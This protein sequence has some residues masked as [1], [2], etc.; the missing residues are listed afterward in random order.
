MSESKKFSLPVIGEVD[1]RTAM[2]AGAATL[3]LAA[4]AAAIK[5]WFEWTGELNTDDFLQKHYRELTHD[6]LQT[7]L[8]KL[9]D[10]ARKETG[11]NVTVKD[12]KPIL[13]VQFAYALNLSICIG[14]RRCAEACHVENNHD[15]PSHQSY[16]RVFEMQK[17]GIDFEKGNASWMNCSNRRTTAN[18][19]RGTGSTSSTSAKRM[20]TTRTNPDRT[21]G[22]TEIM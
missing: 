13:G 15:R 11:K 19:G 7:I 22:P 9:T 17:G 16:I 10:E 5:P 3:G 6:Q 18:A 21:P 14:C 12:H 8:N 2:K 4:W 20:V 1:R